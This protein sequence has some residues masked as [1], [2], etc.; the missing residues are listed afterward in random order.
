[1]VLFVEKRPPRPFIILLI[2]ISHRSSKSSHRLTYFS[3]RSAKKAFQNFLKKW[4]ECGKLLTFSTKF[5]KK[6]YYFYTLKALYFLYFYKNKKERAS[7]GLGLSTPRLKKWEMW[8]E[9]KEYFGYFA[10]N[11]EIITLRC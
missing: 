6:I 8:E 11:D 9:L 7:R 10:Q 4:W 3:H 1:M 2:I 5:D